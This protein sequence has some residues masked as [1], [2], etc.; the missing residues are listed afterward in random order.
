VLINLIGN[1]VKFTNVGEVYVEVSASKNS[2]DLYEITFRVKDTGIGI[3][4]EKMVKLFKPFSQVDAYS[5][6][7][8]G[9][10]GLGLVIS[11][12]LVELMDGK[13][14]VESEVDKGSSFYFSIKAR[15]IS[16][17][18]R[19]PS[20][21]IPSILK[22]KNIVVIDKSKL[23]LQ[24]LDGQLKNWGMNSFTF[25]SEQSSLDYLRNSPETDCIIYNLNHLDSTTR[26]F[27][28]E[29]RGVGEFSDKLIV[30]FCP[31]GRNLVQLQD[32]LTDNLVVIFKPV[33]Y[34]S[35]LKTFKD[36]FSSRGLTTNKFPSEQLNQEK[37]L[38]QGSCLS[39][40]IAEDNVVNQKVA[41]RLVEKLG[42]KV[43]VVENG[44][45][46]VRAVQKQNFDVILMDM[47]M[48]EMNGAEAASQIIDNCRNNGRPV[49]IAV[50]ADSSMV[51]LKDSGFDDAISKP[52]TLGELKEILER[53]SRK[54][55]KVKPCKE[56]KNEID[57]SSKILNE[58]CI[59]FINDI[60]TDADL[61]FF[62]ELLEIYMKDLPIMVNE[63]DLAVKDSDLKKLKFF[64]HKLKGSMVTLG[65]ESVTNICT[66]LENA[67]ERNSA[68]DIIF[69]HNKKLKKC[70]AQVLRE[71]A[72]LRSRY[73]QQSDK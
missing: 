63:I 27:V 9:G 35:L 50:S 28:N 10:T 13:M 44:V 37:I 15:S 36:F 58:E 7:S 19:F 6:R 45:Q 47:I 32:L 46:A 53:W 5:T 21:D 17:D 12:K 30:L 57:Q 64:A 68:D 26:D 18:P 61:R 41:Q 60:K 55:K 4:Q 39:L 56:I 24:T 51:N 8:Y 22:D 71:I 11:K 29:I 31:V 65:V 3:P 33:K 40:L 72:D 16:S 59:T 49:M 34:S 20:Y 14:R 73:L 38:E 66:E 2:D 70:I 42:H 23:S 54:V 62:V 48:P 52:L 43:T 1:A 69:D 25:E 67:A